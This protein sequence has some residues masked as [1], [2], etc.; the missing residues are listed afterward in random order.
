MIIA[1]TSIVRCELLALDKKIQDT[2]FGYVFSKACQYVG[3]NEKVC[4]N[5]R[6]FF[7]QDFLLVRFVEMYNMA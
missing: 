6:V 1:L 5:L 7:C 2:Y 4:K 3:T